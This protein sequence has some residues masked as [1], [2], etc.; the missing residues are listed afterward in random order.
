M[1]ALEL[2]ASLRMMP[3]TMVFHETLRKLDSFAKFGSSFHY[4]ALSNYV[5][6]HRF[7]FVLFQE[8]PFWRTQISKNKTGK[9]IPRKV[10]VEVCSSAAK[11]S[12]TENELGETSRQRLRLY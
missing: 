2:S 4:P 6:Q 10:R 3:N 11:A 1:Q 12:C 7:S 8:F 9:K 5:A